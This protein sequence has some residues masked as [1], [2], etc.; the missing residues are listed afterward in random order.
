MMLLMF[1]N[2]TYVTEY[3]AKSPPED[4]DRAAVTAAQLL[5]KKLQVGGGTA[6]ARWGVGNSGPA[7]LRA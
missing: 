4:V 6:G 7:A 1:H 5:S 3:T 2:A